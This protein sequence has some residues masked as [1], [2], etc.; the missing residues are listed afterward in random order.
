MRVKSHYINDPLSMDFNYKIDRFQFSL[1]LRNI[2]YFL[3]YFFIVIKKVE[4]YENVRILNCVLARKIFMS[5][6]VG[7]SLFWQ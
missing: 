4:I 2:F 1:I 7:S 3:N 5:F 6:W